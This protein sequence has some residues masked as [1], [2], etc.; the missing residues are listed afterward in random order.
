MQ[1]GWRRQSWY[2]SLPQ[3]SDYAS[4]VF[5]IELWIIY[6]VRIFR[7]SNI[8]LTPDTQTYAYLVIKWSVK[9]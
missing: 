4:I 5:T 1:I 2:F 6:L 8:F 3:V 9:H 7:K